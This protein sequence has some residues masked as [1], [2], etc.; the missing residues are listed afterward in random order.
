[1]SLVTQISNSLTAICT[2]IKADR[3][4]RG[5]LS[6]LTTSTKSTIVGA[7]NELKSSISGAGATINDASASTSSVYS[8]QK[9]SDAI[10]AAVSALVNG[11][12]SALDTL[13]ELADALGDDANFSTTISTALAARL[14]FDAAQTLSAPQKVQGNANLGSLSLVQSGDPA[15]DFVAVVTA[16]LA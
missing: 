12:G 9:T 4:L 14:Q 7:L 5:D 2:A 1:M 8:S 15:T 11:A 6:D 10:A 16:G 13:K 3:G